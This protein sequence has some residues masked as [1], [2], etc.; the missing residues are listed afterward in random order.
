MRRYYRWTRARRVCLRSV[1][2]D[3]PRDGQKRLNRCAPG[4]TT[5]G[6]PLQGGAEMV[7]YDPFQCPVAFSPWVHNPREPRRTA[8]SRCDG[9]IDS[10]ECS[11]RCPC[12]IPRLGRAVPERRSSA[13]RVTLTKKHTCKT[14]PFESPALNFAAN[15]CAS[16]RPVCGVG[17]PGWRGGMLD[18]NLCRI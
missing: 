18:P 4:H 8:G 11:V 1:M 14:N 2:A 10:P 15:G 3:Q 13:N 16:K 6:A 7:P 5:P 17:P 9:L 12:S